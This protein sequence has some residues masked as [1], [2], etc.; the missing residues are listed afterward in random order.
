MMPPVHMAD[1]GLDNVDILRRTPLFAG[2]PY[3]EL[4]VLGAIMRPESFTMGE[5]VCVRGE[6]ADS[7]H[8]VASG[9]LEVVLPGRETPLRLVKPGDVIGEYGMFGSRL[10]TATVR[11]TTMSRLLSIDQERFR[12]FLLQFPQATLA[13]LEVTVARLVAREA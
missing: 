7:V 1:D 10:R 5:T 3:A 4:T 8:V 2:I 6:P 11:A 13:L 12:Q 9:E